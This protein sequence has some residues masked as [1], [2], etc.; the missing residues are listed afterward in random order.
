M[1]KNK[2]FTLKEQ[3]LHMP[4]YRYFEGK[5]I[6]AENKLLEENSKNKQVQLDEAKTYTDFLLIQ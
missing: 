4:I 5:K 3:I 6:E 2:R 1:D